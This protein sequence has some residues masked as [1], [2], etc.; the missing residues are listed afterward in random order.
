MDNAVVSTVKGKPASIGQ[1]VT[2][3]PGAVVQSATIGDG[4]MIGMGAVVQPGASVGAD[5][6]VDAGAVVPAGTK[7]PAGQLWTGVPAKFLR[8]LSADEMSYL[9][10]TAVSTSKKMGAPRQ[11]PPTAAE[12][13]LTGE[14]AET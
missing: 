2:I 4:A 11:M 13:L 9:R 7:I 6:F 3:M 10:S 14:A 5:C 8:T 12:P 1:D